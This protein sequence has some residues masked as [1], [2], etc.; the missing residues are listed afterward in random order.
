MQHRCEFDGCEL[1]PHMDQWSTCG[2]FLEVISSGRLAGGFFFG[3]DNELVLPTTA[4][5]ERR[6]IPDWLHFSNGTPQTSAA[7]NITGN[8][9]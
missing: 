5:G 1:S 8:K 3:W 7:G 2:L 4:R 9:R 6:V